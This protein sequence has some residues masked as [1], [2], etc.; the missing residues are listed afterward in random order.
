MLSPLKR[1][2][3]SEIGDFLANFDQSHPEKSVSQ[4]KEIAKHAR[5]AGL[6]D[7]T[8]ST[9]QPLS[10]DKKIWEGF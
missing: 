4:A 7:G 2:F 1:S 8:L 5:I 9:V 10:A 3:V 6:R